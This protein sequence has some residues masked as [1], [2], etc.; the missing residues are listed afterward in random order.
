MPFA[1]SGERIKRAHTHREE[2][3]KRWSD[4]CNIKAY[5]TAVEVTDN[6]H[7]V[8]RV[9][10][11]DNT[12][13]PIFSIMFGELLYQLRASL[14][15]LAYEASIFQTGDDP[16]TNAD[17]VE[18]IVRNSADDL[19]KARWKIRDMEPE[20]Q[21]LIERVQPYHGPDV[22]PDETRHRLSIG[23]LNHFAR[24]DRHRRLHVGKDWVMSAPGISLPPGV[25]WSRVAIPTS[26]FVEDERGVLRLT[27]RGW[28]PGM[29][30]KADPDVAVEI[31]LDEPLPWDRYPQPL[32]Q[33]CDDMIAGV[34]FVLGLFR[35]HFKPLP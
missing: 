19:D 22:R 21:A 33:L 20:T 1:D 11:S 8:V 18:F 12:I 17:Y 6:G 28:K 35:S 14:D 30:I 13:L 24:I 32:F 16:P 5:S 23:A 15:A 3:T 10:P 27:L 29:E 26:R 9:V 31:V 34:E 25:T 2:L 4:F 7:A